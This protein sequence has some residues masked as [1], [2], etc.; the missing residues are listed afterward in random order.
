MITKL[1][2]AFVDA[3]SDPTVRQRFIDLGQVIPP[4]HQFPPQGFGAY[5][6]AEFEKWTPILNAAN[7]KAN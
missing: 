6:S 4:L 7:I 2:A 3:M 5:H 1:N